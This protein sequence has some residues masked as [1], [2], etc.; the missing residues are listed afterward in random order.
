MAR[1]SREA[2]VSYHANSMERSPGSS[3]LLPAVPRNELFL[4]V[5]VAKRPSCPR[6]TLKSGNHPEIEATSG[7]ASATASPTAAPFAQS[8][9]AVA[10]LGRA[11]LVL[12][13]AVLADLAVGSRP[14]RAKLREIGRR[15]LLRLR[16]VEFRRAASQLTARATAL[17]SRVKRWRSQS[18]ETHDDR[19]KWDRWRLALMRGAT[20]AGATT[21]VTLACQ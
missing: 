10:D 20:I 12:G 15:M 18:S 7:E 16:E 3:P 8:R 9:R 4:S 13:R 2:R 21:L 1:P 5:R 19:T 17:W 6:G 14:L 11:F